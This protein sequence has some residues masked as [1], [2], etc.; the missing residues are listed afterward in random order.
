MTTFPGLATFPGTST[1][2]A[3]GAYVFRPPTQQIPFRFE[4]TRRLI[5]YIDAGLN[6]RRTAGTWVTEPYT[7]ADDLAASDRFYP[8]GRENHVSLGQRDELIA[9]G[10][11]AYIYL[12]TT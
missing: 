12:E 9:A 5:G 7:T 1:F 6:V 4:R 8:G 11:G 3:E 2:P 10:F